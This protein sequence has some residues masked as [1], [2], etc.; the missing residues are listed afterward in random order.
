MGTGCTTRTVSSSAPKFS[1]YSRALSEEEAMY[2]LF[3]IY[4]QY[5]ELNYNELSTRFGF[6]PKLTD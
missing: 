2:I 1:V 4:V 3:W 5:I 6:L